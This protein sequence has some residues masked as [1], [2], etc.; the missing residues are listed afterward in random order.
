MKSLEYNAINH[1]QYTMK[2]LLNNKL[3]SE[4]VGIGEQHNS[5]LE[6][7]KIICLKI[8]KFVKIKSNKKVRIGTRNLPESQ[9]DKKI[10]VYS[11]PLLPSRM[12]MRGRPLAKQH[13]EDQGFMI[14]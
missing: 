10:W 4:E 5:N 1:I 8:G 11:V 2:C 9:V 12:P 14:L 3:L 7:H 6:G 13:N